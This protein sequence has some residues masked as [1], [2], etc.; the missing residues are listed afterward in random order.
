MPVLFSAARLC[1][2]RVLV[3]THRWTVLAASAYLP[4]GRVLGVWLQ[5]ILNGTLVQPVVVLAVQP[6][7]QQAASGCL[8]TTAASL[9]RTCC[10]S[11]CLACC[12]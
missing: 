8:H 9:A 11:G 7:M 10:A 1:M 2:R 3:Q 12:I 5:C 6:D 4:E